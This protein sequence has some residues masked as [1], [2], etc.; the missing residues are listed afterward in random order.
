M[1]AEGFDKRDI[2]ELSRLLAHPHQQVRQEAQ[3]AL[4]GKGKEAIAPLAKIAKESKSPLA[5]L[6]ALWGLGQIGRKEAKAFDP[7]LAVLNDT[8]AEVRAQAAR[9][10]GESKS[11][12]VMMAL[13]KRTRDDEPR[14]RFFAAQSLGKVAAA[15]DETF[16]A[17]VR[18]D[19]ERV[20]RSD[21]GNDSYLRHAAV[22][23]LARLPLVIRD[24]DLSPETAPAVRMGLL[25]ALRRQHSKEAE[26]FLADVDPRIVTEAARAIHD[27]PIPRP[28]ELAELLDGSAGS[29]QKLAR[30]LRPVQP[31]DPIP[32]LMRALNACFRLG[33]QKH[34]A[35]IAH[36]AARAEIPEMLRREALRM[37]A[38]W[39]KPSGRDRVTNLW[40]PFEPRPAK[41]AAERFA[42]FW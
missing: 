16:Q 37:L 27:E 32:A 13:A 15:Q 23:A 18:V 35:W 19:L 8:D 25:L 42:P 29:E 39:E 40:H 38:D 34:A 2:D 22:V 21:A 9:V 7:V 3:F 26:R 33:E 14:V 6:H 4:A 30:L 5:R 24:V 41:N 36:L 10:L 11:R 12:P 28:A 1:L 17:L 31:L 20:L